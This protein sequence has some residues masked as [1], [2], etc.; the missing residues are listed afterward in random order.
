[1]DKSL[2][3]F[4]RMELL[5]LLLKASEMNEALVAENTSLRKSA[6]ARKSVP[7]QQPQEQPQ[8]LPQAA[9]VGSIAEAALQA[10][11]YFDAAQRAADD[12][13]REI[14]YLRDQVAARAAASGQGQIPQQ[15][16]YRQQQVNTQAHVQDAQMKASAIINQANAQ[17]RAIVAD[18]RVRSEA[19]VNDARVQSETM[20][21][22]AN[23]QSHI[24]VAQASRR[25]DAMLESVGRR[26]ADPYP[27]SSA[28]HRG[29]HMKLAD[30]VMV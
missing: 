1:M 24:I 10:N 6:A 29:R 20:I 7:A 26:T 5:Q 8:R 12:Y 11:G 17:A 9:K 4:N 22:D 18:A 21:A 27:T 2:K 23:R 14:K 30:G 3:D 16:G 19:M 13:L 25:A 15:T 28:S